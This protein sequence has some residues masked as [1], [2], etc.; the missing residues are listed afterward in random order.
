MGRVLD[1][2]FPIDC[3][4]CGAPGSRACGPC[5]A[6]L[7]LAPRVY[8]GRL[9]RAAAGFPYAQ[10]LVRRLLHDVK[11]EGWTCA[12]GPL[13]TLVRRWSAK[14]GGIFP[15]EAT[16]VPVPLHASRLRS[17]GFNQAEVLAR[18]LASAS[19]RVCVPDLLARVR[20][21]KPQ[22]DALH[23]RGNVRGAFL[24]RALPAS[25][26]GSAFIIVD[27]VRTSGSTMAE[28]AEA[29]RRSGAGAVYGFSLAWGSGLPKEAE[30]T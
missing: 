27:D 30:N 2:F 14:A 28:C 7:P 1:F 11:Y 16:V 12:F 19:G 20:E 10:P 23:R 29:L 25:K 18:A 13:E 15:R 26:R 6:A 5:L 24:S 21:T 3:L 17:R 8:D 22:T 4:A 9:L